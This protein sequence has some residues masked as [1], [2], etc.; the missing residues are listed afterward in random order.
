[1]T[2]LL[3]T[4]HGETVDNANK[5]MQGQTQGE[6]NAAGV[7]E[8]EAL[9]Q[10][11]KNDKIDVFVSS[12]LK[13]AIDTCRILAIP[14]G[15]EVV[16]TALLRE[17]DWGSWTGKYIPSLQY[18]NEWPGDVESLAHLKDRAQKFLDWITENY[19][20]LTVVA[21]GHGIVNKAIQSVYYKKPMNEIAKMDNCEVRKLVLG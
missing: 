21:V 2:T 17:R 5:I 18:L 3:L 20:G 9:A 11:L 13:R 4:R 16:T 6:L 8:A 10:R 7:A 12:D 19:A 14:H 1:M 15:Q